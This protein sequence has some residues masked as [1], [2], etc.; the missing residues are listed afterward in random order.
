MAIDKTSF[1]YEKQRLA[2][3][4]S[5][6]GEQ[7]E[8]SRSTAD[9]MKKNV[10][11]L[12]RSMWE[13]VN[14]TPGKGDLTDLADIWQFQTD[15]VRE[16][17]RAV[18]AAAKASRLERMMNSPY[19]GRLD[20][21]ED[22]QS[23]EESVYIGISNFS[24]A[25][26]LE[27]LVYDWRAPVSSMF[28]DYETGGAGYDCPAGRIEGNVG[29]KRQFRIWRGKIGFM[30]DCSLAID[31]EILQDILSR[32]A[33]SRM[34]TIVT[35]IQRDQN[36]VIRNDTHRLLVVEG[37]AGSG[38][39]SIAL[40]RAA[41][42]LYRYRD[43]ITAENIAIFSPNSIFSD[44]ISEVLPEL[45]EENIR[46]TTFREYAQSI[47]AG[48]LAAE[49][50]GGMME[51]ILA[52]KRD[53]GYGSRVRGIEYKAS[54][55]FKDLLDAYALHIENSRGFEDVCHNGVCIESGREIGDYYRDGLKFLPVAKRLEKI[56]NRLV[57]KLDPMIRT[58]SEEIVPVLA[59]AGEFPNE[60]EVRARSALMAREEFR[61]VKE[62]IERM[63]AIDAAEC[64][65]GLFGDT[66]LCGRL[67]G[68]GLP[69][70]FE[71]I[72]YRTVKKLEKGE[73]FNEDVAPLLYLTGLLTGINPLD[74]IKHVIIDEVQD[75]SI[76][77]LELLHRLFRNSTLTLLGDPCQSINP[78]G[79]NVDGRAIP[80]IFASGSSE[81]V[82]LNKSY[83][84]TRQITEF[85]RKIL[86]IGEAAA[87]VERDGDEPEIIRRRSANELYA[88]VLNDIKRFSEDGCHSIAVICR[89]AEAG[90]RAYEELSGSLNLRLVKGNDEEYVKGVSV[91]PSYLSKGL[92]FDA[93]LVLCPDG[94]DYTAPEEKKL[95]YTVCTRALHRLN[96]YRLEK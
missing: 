37:P 38:K 66:E 56:R 36:R 31:D 30:F 21:T 15:L 27:C 57:S 75:Y 64:Y 83:R 1:E 45:G 61:P 67:A 77:Q 78:Y 25:R 46:R 12:Q 72:S 28:Y 95:F 44:Y 6:I 80:D 85:C 34:K 82:R 2:A 90:R 93:V 68:G 8:E 9:G 92:E 3:V 18:F 65:A 5:K 89:T 13:Q 7:L 19:F 35:S 41:F 40:H 42:L 81:M 29:L 86:G 53:E 79:G 22:G 73:I 88:C 24:D 14:P 62:L 52:G 63:T 49:D 32:S 39:T 84:S 87:I 4:L 96:V 54:R 20:F 60:A 59:E 76:I 23:A 94:D 43:S 70:E 71:E 11:T 51:F 55:G 50:A 58:R 91:I 10:I 26:T 48:R 47:L 69:E 33:D 17:D 16:A 74:D